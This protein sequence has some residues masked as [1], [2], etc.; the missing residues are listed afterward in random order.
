MC[1]SVF[2]KGRWFEEAAISILVTENTSSLWIANEPIHTPRLAPMNWPFCD[3]LRG[4]FGHC[5]TVY[6]IPVISFQIVEQLGYLRMARKYSLLFYMPGIHQV[7]WH[8]KQSV[9]YNMDI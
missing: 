5:I 1:P 8:E 6:H 7:F 9:I 3:K 4:L 2:H